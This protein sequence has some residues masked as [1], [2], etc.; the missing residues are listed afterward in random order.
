[1]STTL[2]RM[3]LVGTSEIAEMFGVSRQY[4]DRLTRL[5]GFPEPIGEIRAGRI[6]ERSTIEAWARMT[7]RM[8]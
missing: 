6:W 4:I 5:D 1:M 7:G 8:S 2:D 3:D